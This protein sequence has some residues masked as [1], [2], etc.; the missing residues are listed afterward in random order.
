M[1]PLAARMPTGAT[2]SIHARFMKTPRHGTP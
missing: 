1:K 2:G